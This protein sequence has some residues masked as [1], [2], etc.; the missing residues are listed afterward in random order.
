MA[1]ATKPAS[2]LSEAAKAGEGIPIELA[3]TAGAE[4]I[5]ILASTVSPETGASAPEETRLARLVRL[6]GMHQSQCSSNAEG[7]RPANFAGVHH[8][9]FGHPR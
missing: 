7:A 6:H 5:E 9:N 8:D 4:L 1:E 3:A 2:E